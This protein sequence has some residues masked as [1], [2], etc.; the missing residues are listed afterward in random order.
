MQT[1]KASIAASAG[2]HD[3]Q[4]A[5]KTSCDS[6]WTSSSAVIT[7]KGTSSGFRKLREALMARKFESHDNIPVAVGA[8]PGLFIGSYGAA[9]NLEALKT[10]GITH[11]L[12]VSPTLPLNFPDVFTYLQLQV[13]DLSS[14]RISDYFDDAFGFIDSALSSGG[15]VLVH[16]FMGISRSSTVILA[17]LIARRGFSLADALC[18]LRRVRPQV[19]PNSGFYREL[20][21]LEAK[22]NNSAS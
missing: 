9:N 4:L 20:V 14:V 19:Q 8:V 1:A 15:K 3:D 10:T 13:A 16:C 7:R 6:T 12:C 5:N 17:Y 22:Q 18:K 2:S 21:A 11:V